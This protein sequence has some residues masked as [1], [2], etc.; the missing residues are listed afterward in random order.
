MIS[1]CEWYH[2][3]SASSP[4]PAVALEGEGES[5]TR[6][7]ETD[8]PTPLPLLLRQALSR[9]QSCEAEGLDDNILQERVAE[10]LGDLLFASNRE[11]ART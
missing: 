3:P 7:Q 11:L 6:S 8:S 1:S 9:F 5:A 4:L 10:V 2:P